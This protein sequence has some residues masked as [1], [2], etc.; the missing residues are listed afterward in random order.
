MKRPPQYRLV[1]IVDTKV[2]HDINGMTQ[3]LI[4]YGTW[5][6]DDLSTSVMKHQEIHSV[7]RC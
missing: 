2:D 6:V 3:F 1:R 5:I 4:N 7:P